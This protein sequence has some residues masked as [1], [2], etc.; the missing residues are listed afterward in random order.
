MKNHKIFWLIIGVALFA[1][2]LLTMDMKSWLGIA[3]LIGGLAILLLVSVHTMFISGKV[4][5]NFF[6]HG[7]DASVKFVPEDPTVQNS[8]DVW[9]QM[10]DKK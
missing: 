7:A 1:G 9:E 2:G 10:K 3:L 4:K 6:H 8:Q 5:G